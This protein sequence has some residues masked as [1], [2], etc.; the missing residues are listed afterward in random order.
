MNTPLAITSKNNTATAQHGLKTEKK[1]C[2]LCNGEGFQ[3]LPEARKNFKSYFGLVLCRCIASKCICDQKPP[4]MYMDEQNFQLLPCPCREVRRSLSVIKGLYA[5]SNIPP[6]YRFRRLK[7]FKTDHPDPKISIC[8]AQALDNARFFLRELKTK[9]DFVRGWYF[10]GQPGSGKTLLS[11]LILNECI[12]QNRNEVRYTKITR[13]FFNQIRASFNLESSLYGQSEN[14][15]QEVSNVQILVIDDFGIQ[16]DSD[17]EQRTLYDLID[18]RYEHN[19]ITII[20]SNTDPRELRSL[21]GGRIFSRLKEMTQS[22]DM[23]ADD[24]RDKFSNF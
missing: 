3:L 1:F 13:D 6:K 15:F 8:L 16:K 20:T 24:Y 2:Q 19:K 11:C 18:Y 10:H 17:W 14:L 22:Q 5:K 23:I 4:Y 12:L 21:F 7:E 9:K